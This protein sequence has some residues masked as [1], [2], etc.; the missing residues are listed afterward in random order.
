M[1]SY[2]IHNLKYCQIESIKEIFPD[3]EADEMNFC[4]FSTSGV[5]GSYVTIEDVEK[6]VRQFGFDPPGEGDSGYDEEALNPHVTFLIISPRI[7]RMHYGNVRVTSFADL[8]Y[9]KKLRAS[10]HKAIKKIG[11]AR[12]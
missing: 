11:V 6:S 1:S 4:L 2:A 5:H 3:G 7:V 9:L 8:A 12:A 10:S